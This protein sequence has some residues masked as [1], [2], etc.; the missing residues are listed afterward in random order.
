[1]GPTEYRKV[2]KTNVSL[3]HVPKHIKTTENYLRL[4]PLNAEIYRKVPKY[5]N[6]DKIHR[7]VRT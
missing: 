5:T 7:N 3:S 4:V 1:M 6:M 2:P